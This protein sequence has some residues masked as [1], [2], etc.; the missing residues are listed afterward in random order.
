M[1]FVEVQKKGKHGD[2]AQELLPL[3]MPSKIALPF[4]DKVWADFWR[5]NFTNSN[6][7][8]RIKGSHGTK[9]LLIPLNL[10]IRQNGSIISR[11]EILADFS[12]SWTIRSHHSVHPSKIQF[13]VGAPAPTIYSSFIQREDFA[14]FRG[15]AV[16][17]FLCHC[18]WKAFV[19]AGERLWCMRLSGELLLHEA[20]NSRAQQPKDFT[21]N[22]ISSRFENIPSWQIPHIIIVILGSKEWICKHFTRAG[23][24]RVKIVCTKKALSFN[25][26]NMTLA[27][28]W[29]TYILAT[30]DLLIW[31]PTQHQH[32][33]AKRDMNLPPP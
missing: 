11:E 15:C 10:F 23:S 30:Q 28:N 4:C 1:R 19:F 9:S 2:C 5:E 13:L 33:S 7:L 12:L 8:A 27:F 20:A 26:N 14:S 21:L 24:H 32:Y 18:A 17:N 29:N 6:E 25:Q 22:T 31:N 16:A 3:W